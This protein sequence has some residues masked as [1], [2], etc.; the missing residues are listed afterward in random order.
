MTDL[1]QLLRDKHR[2]D[3]FVDECVV[4][5]RSMRR[6]DAWVLKTTWSPVTMVGYE[7]KAARGDFLRDDKWPA[8]LPVCNLFYFVTTG[9]DIIKIPE[10]PEGCGLMYSTRKGTRLYTKVKASRREAKL[11]AN[12]MATV[13][14]NRAK[15]LEPYFSARGQRQRRGEAIERTRAE[16]LDEWEEWLEENRRA[17]HVGYRVSGWLADTARRTAEENKQLREKLVR[18][19]T[20]RALL[21]KHGVDPEASEWQSGQRLAEA[22]GV[23][24]PRLERDLR[25][26][27]KLLE[28]A[29]EMVER[30]R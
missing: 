21:L 24:P 29:A 2:E 6:L 17:K 8:Y 7:I 23:I 14:M 10:V 3:V 18:W 20:F 15:I 27:A 1:L 4:S 9:P 22:I 28:Q 12:L 11:P 13:L 26:H 19:G 25:H 30:L 5:R 16:R